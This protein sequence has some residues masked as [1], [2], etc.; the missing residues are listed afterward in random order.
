LAITNQ[1]GSDPVIVVQYEGKWLDEL[2]ML[3]MDIL[4]LKTLTLIKKT[5]ELI[6]FARKIDVDIENVDLTDKKTFK[7]LSNGWTDGVFQFESAGMKKYLSDLKPNKF[8][9]LIAMVSLYRP[10]PMQFIETFI[11]RK[12]GKEKVKFV[13]PLAKNALKETYGVT[14][15]QEQVMQIAREMGGF[16]GAEADTLRKAIS[17]KKIKMMEKLKLK[18]VNGAEEN[19]VPKHITEKIWKDWLDFANYAFNKS[20]AT[21][22]AFIAFQTAFLKTHYHVEFMAALLSLEDKPEKIPYF[23]NECKDMGIVVE[24]P[25]INHSL[26]EFMVVGKRIKFGLKAIKNV[27]SAA[28]R[29]IISQRKTEGEFKNIFEF[30]SRVDPMSVNKAVLESLIC[31]G[32]MD[33]LEG[34]RAQ[35]FAAIE[36]Q[37][38]Y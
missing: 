4:G 28:I 33:E 31:S 14:V 24:P 38:N 35:K 20:H 29:S 2:K 27:G 8:E 18:F 36:K 5:I 25:S 23:I 26:E 9:D 22:Y 6:K 19:G 30:S 11:N 10:G 3:K 1:K 16:T 37:I 21:A 12:H 34:N 17:K 32:A 15:Y 13:H 7:L